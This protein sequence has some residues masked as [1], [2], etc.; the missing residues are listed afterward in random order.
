LRGS[1]KSSFLGIFDIGEST[2]FLLGREG[3]SVLQP[4]IKSCREG[5]SVEETSFEETGFMFLIFSG[6]SK[7]S[8]QSFWI[9]IFVL[10][11]FTNVFSIP[12]VELLFNFVIV[13]KI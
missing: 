4:R 12:F 13:S 7:V 8:S 5:V 9:S 11:I 1:T 10:S 2:D 6:V 3:A